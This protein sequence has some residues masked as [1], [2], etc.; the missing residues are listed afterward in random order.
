MTVPAFT[1]EQ[2]AE[3]TY[4]KEAALR[5]TASPY[6]VKK[7]PPHKLCNGSFEIF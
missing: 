7:E 4:K 5:A 6:L 2:M 3:F 1:E